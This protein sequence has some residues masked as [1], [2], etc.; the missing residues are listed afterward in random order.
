MD[1]DIFD[2]VEVMDTLGFV[3]VEGIENMK[4]VD[5]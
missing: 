2:A 5:V 4:V 3:D 1:T